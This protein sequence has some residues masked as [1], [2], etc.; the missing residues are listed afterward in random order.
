MSDDWRLK[1][2]VH[3][4]GRVRTLLQH[5]D[6]TDLEHQ[7]ETAFHDRVVVSNE[8]STIFFY[9]GQREQVERAREVAR[10]RGGGAVGARLIGGGFGGSVLGLLPPGSEV[11]DGAIE[12]WAGPGARLL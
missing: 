3:E 7:L 10:L 4:H 6:A 9:A 2:E 1:I 11:P 12:V 5:V 8:G